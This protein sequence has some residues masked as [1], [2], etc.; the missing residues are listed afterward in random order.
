[1][2][3]SMMM[4]LSANQSGRPF[5]RKLHRWLVFVDTA[6]I[7]LYGKIGKRHSS[8]CYLWVDSYSQFIF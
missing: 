5:V 7:S 3:R 8:S 4:I 2:F 6:Q 1:M